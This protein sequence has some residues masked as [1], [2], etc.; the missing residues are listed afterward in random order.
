VFF[1]KP[2]IYL[3]ICGIRAHFVNDG[4]FGFVTVLPNDA[5]G[6]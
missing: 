2:G 4:M 6:Q 3:V 1:P 5:T